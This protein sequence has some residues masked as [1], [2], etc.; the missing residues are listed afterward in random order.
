MVEN[1]YGPYKAF[2]EFCPDICQESFLENKGVLMI[3]PNP[4]GWD[5]ISGF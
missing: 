3:N 5:Y 2:L 1:H 4:F